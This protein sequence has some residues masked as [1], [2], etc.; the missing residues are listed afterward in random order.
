MIAEEEDDSRSKKRGTKRGRQEESDDDSGDDDSLGALTQAGRQCPA[1]LI[2]DGRFLSCH[3]PASACC[4][5]VLQAVKSGAGR[6]VK[7]ANSVGGGGSVSGRSVGKTSKAS[8]K[9]AASRGSS[10]EHAGDRFKAKG[11]GTGGDVKGKSKA[12][13]NAADLSPPR[14]QRL[15]P[16]DGS[17]FFSTLFSVL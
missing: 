15:R 2:V 12:S 1:Q 6:A 8:M 11:K 17:K 5:S 16:Q 7:F 10:K 14:K 4:L 13:T 9:S 3:Q